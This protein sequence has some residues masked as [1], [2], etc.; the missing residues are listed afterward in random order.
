MQDFQWVNTSA[1]LAQLCQQWQQQ[2]FV[3]LDTEFVRVDTYYPNTGLIQLAT[4]AGNYLLDPLVIDDWSP[5]AALLE[6]PAVVKVVR[7]WK[8][9]NAFLAVC[10]GHSTI[11]S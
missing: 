1:Q 6:N 3:V 9:S 5:F 4:T 7:I 10:R 11:P 2:P 8:C